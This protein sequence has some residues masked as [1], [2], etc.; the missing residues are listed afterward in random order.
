M[1]FVAIGVLWQF[2]QNRDN[3]RTSDFINT[4]AVDAPTLDE[5]VNEMATR[6][7]GWKREHDMRVEKAVGYQKEEDKNTFKKIEWVHFYET[8]LT[9]ILDFLDI[10]EEVK[11]SKIWVQYNEEVEMKEAERVRQEEEKKVKKEKDRKEADLEFVRKLLERYPEEV[12]A[13]ANHQARG[14]YESE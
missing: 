4:I 7:V 8:V 9:D 14:C 10:E 5:L 2:Y 3:Y 11:K 12:K 1:P 13:I 6:E